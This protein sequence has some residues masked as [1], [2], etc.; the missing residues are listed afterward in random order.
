[1][2]ITDAH[3]TIHLWLL[4]HDQPVHSF[5]LT[6]Y[7]HD[8]AFVAS[9][10]HTV[11]FLLSGELI[12]KI[13]LRSRVWILE[14]ESIAMVLLH[15]RNVKYSQS[16]L[17]VVS[18]QSVVIVE[19]QI[20]L[21][22]KIVIEHLRVKHSSNEQDIW[23]WPQEELFLLVRLHFEGEGLIGQKICHMFCELEHILLFLRFINI[24]ILFLIVNLGKSGLLFLCWLYVVH[25]IKVPLEVGVCIERITRLRV[26]YYREK[27]QKQ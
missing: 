19:R 2:V 20:D 10:C 26:C 14:V 15:V 16:L 21:A 6:S 23:T 25:R 27:R 13:D 22:V 7:R 8:F 18:D 11:L 9:I 17:P 5:K 3:Q 1:M 24:A 12:R 4:L